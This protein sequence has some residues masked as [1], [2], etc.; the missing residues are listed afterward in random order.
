MR[1]AARADWDLAAACL[2]RAF[3]DD[4]V[5]AYLFPDRETRVAR[6][7]RLYRL[8]I[9]TFASGGVVE[10]DEGCHSA[11]IWQSPSPRRPGPLQQVVMALRSLLVLREATSRAEELQKTTD[12]AHP[13]E[14]HWY[15]AML[16]TD[17]PKQGEGR[18]SAVLA[19]V[20]EACDHSGTPA[21]LESSKESNIPFYQR[22]GFNVQRELEVPDGPRLWTMLRKPR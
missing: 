19:P 8:A 7:S 17:P 18:G 11:A 15:L 20:L 2:A 10:I 21:Y 3:E 5:C 13:R 6:A 14:P 4:P 16:G 1:E 22:H 9:R 12:S